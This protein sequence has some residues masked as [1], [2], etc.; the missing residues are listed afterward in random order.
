MNWIVTERYE[1]LSNRN[2]LRAEEIQFVGKAANIPG[3][4]MFRI[5]DVYDRQ[6]QKPIILFTN[7]LTFGA[8]TIAQ[9]YE[10]R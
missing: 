2:I 3:Q 10:N 5:V 1:A 6:K 9:I 8:S 7:H 4:Q